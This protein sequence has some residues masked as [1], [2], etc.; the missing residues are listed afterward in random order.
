MTG[1]KGARYAHITGWGRYV[2]EQVLTN[3]DLE[4][5]VDT[6]DELIVSRTGIVPPTIN[7]ED[8]DP[9]GAGLDLTPNRATRRDLRI[10]VNNSFGFGG[11]NTALVFRRWDP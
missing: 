3:A 1:S 7:L 8:P 9:V 5:M 11:Q 6:N 2:P 4:R 10:A